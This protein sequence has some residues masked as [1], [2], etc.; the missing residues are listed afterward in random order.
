MSGVKAVSARTCIWGSPRTR[1]MPQEE[2]NAERHE[3][4]VTMA[5]LMFWLLRI[6]SA[7]SDDREAGASLVEYALLLALIALVALVALQFLGNST[8]NSLSTSGNS[9]FNSP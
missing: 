5:G 9:L 2:T 8:Q 1:G 3:T 6:P 4:G 7:F